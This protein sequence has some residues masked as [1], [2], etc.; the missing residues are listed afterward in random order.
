MKIVNICPACGEPLSGWHCGN[1]EC[2]SCN[3]TTPYEALVAVSEKDDI[4][5]CPHCGFE[6]CFSFWE[7]QNIEIFIATQGGDG[8]LT[9]AADLYES[10][11][12]RSP[13]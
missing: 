6:E 9:G 4:I 11:K 3:K 12:S 10:R 8:S 1:T 7:M 2:K 13:K 5:A